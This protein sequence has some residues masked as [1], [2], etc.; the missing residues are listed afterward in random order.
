MLE[1]ELLGECAMENYSEISCNVHRWLDLGNTF[2]HRT[3][4]FVNKRSEWLKFSLVDWTGES[5]FLTD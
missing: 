1:D 4:M 2:L 3:D 5:M